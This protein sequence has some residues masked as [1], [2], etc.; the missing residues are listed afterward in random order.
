MDDVASGSVDAVSSAP[1]AGTAITIAASAPQVSRSR[2]RRPASLVVALF[3]ILGPPQ[4]LD[5]RWAIRFRFRSAFANA[6]A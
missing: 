5:N 4:A 2:A 1:V 6:N 3:L